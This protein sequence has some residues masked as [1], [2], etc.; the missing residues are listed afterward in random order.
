MPRQSFRL[1]SSHVVLETAWLSSCIVRMPVLPNPGM[2]ALL[3]ECLRLEV[4]VQ[5]D[6]KRSKRK[7]EPFHRFCL[8]P[9]SSHTPAIPPIGGQP[10]SQPV[11]KLALTP[12]H[13]C[14]HPEKLGEQRSDG[15]LRAG[16][17]RRRHPQLT[18]WFK[19][20][21]LGDSSQACQPLHSEL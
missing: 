21:E 10:T 2:V 6:V 13:T 19:S 3:E 12:S 17:L 16:C 14:G 4:P 11:P 9:K 20:G 1:K 5:P 7:L 8:E 15:C 18:A